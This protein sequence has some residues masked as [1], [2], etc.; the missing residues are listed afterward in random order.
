MLITMIAA[1]PAMPDYAIERA[2]QLGFVEFG[3]PARQ[4]RQ[5]PRFIAEAATS[6]P[7]STG[8]RQGYRPGASDNFAP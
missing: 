3:N 2:L 4:H 8:Q 6:A 7:P 1:G 5:L